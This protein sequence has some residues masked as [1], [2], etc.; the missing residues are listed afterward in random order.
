MDVSTLFNLYAFDVM[1]D[2]AFGKDYRMVAEGKRHWALDLLSD[3]MKPVG[4]RIP[5]WCF[6]L[7]TTIPG[8][9]TGFFKF[10]DFC[11]DEL[12]VRIKDEEKGLGGDI[13]GWILKAYSE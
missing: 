5:M 9:M 11:R 10:L 4:Y 13:T 2:L 7:A 8:A 3:G 6:R 1:G 12:E